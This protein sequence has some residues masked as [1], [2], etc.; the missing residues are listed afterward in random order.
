[1]HGLTWQIFSNGKYKSVLHR[2][3][4]N[5]MKARISV[6]SLHS[7]PFQCKIGPSPTLID[8]SNPRRYKDTDFA[9]FLEYITSPVPKTKNFLESMKLTLEN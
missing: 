3:R 6:A 1:M 7:L 5:S 2:V 8:E 4:V 9:S